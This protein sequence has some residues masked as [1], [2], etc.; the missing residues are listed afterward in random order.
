MFAN[1]RSLIKKYLPVLHSDS[2]PKNIFLENSICTIFKRNINLKK[3]LS[4]SLCA[5]NKNEKKHC[6]IKNCD[7]CDIC[8]RYLIS[9][10]TFTCKVTYRKYYIKDDFDCNGMNVIYE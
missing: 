4:P 3:I 10:N 5:K 2:D 8:K 7:K 9:D 1:M 6:V